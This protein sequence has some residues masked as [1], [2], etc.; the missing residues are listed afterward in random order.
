MKSLC[1]TVA[2]Q[3]RPKLWN[4]EDEE[5]TALVA[6]TTTTEGKVRRRVCYEEIKNGSSYNCL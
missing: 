3:R 6:V 1:E 4:M 5:S 2:S